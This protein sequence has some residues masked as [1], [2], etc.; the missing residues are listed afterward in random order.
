VKELPLHSEF[1]LG[2]VFKSDIDDRV[3]VVEFIGRKFV[4]CRLQ[5]KDQ[6]KSIEQHYK[7]NTLHSL[8]RGFLDKAKF[9]AFR[10]E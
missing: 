1:K 3:W 7:P 5:G 9:R 8:R 10:P 6:I 2:D 4:R